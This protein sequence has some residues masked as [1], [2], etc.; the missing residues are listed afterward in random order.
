[1]KLNKWPLLLA[2]LII[3]AFYL[4]WE[5]DI[6]SMS[7][8]LKESLVR[9]DLIFLPLLLLLSSYIV[10]KIVGETSQSTR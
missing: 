7:P 2:L 9:Y 4:L 3:W 5:Y 8:Y 1:M 6:Q 10:Y